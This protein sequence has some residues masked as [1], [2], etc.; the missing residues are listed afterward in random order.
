MNTVSRFLSCALAGALLS[1]TGCASTPV[2]E[3]VNPDPLEPFNRSMYSF[4]DTL[5]RAILKPVAKGYVAITPDFVRTGV[6]NFFSNISDL[7]VFMNDLL[8]GKFVQGTQDG[9]RFLLNSTVGLLGL[10]DV[11]TPAGLP[12]HQ[13]DFGQT[14]AVWGWDNSAYLVL[15]ILGPSTLRDSLGL[16]GDYPVGLYANLHT[17]YTKEAEI[18]GVETVSTRANLLAATNV[19]EAAALDPYAFTRDAYLQRRRNLIYDG[20]PPPTPDDE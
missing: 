19:L 10:F 20:H 17:T 8:Q 18:F 9:G 7:A 5:D 11:A 16:V 2:G 4:N 12:H 13:E 3:A 14:M 15:P 1:L 6:S